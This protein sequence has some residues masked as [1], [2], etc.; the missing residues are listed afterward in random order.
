MS[1][2]NVSANYPQN[3]SQEKYLL[4]EVATGD[5]SIYGLGAYTSLPKLALE[6]AIRI[7]KSS[8]SFSNIR[9]APA[10]KHHDPMCIHVEGRK[11]RFAPPS[12]TVPSTR[13]LTPVE[14]KRLSHELTKALHGL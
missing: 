13:P 12:R 2:Y 9:T 3:K 10:Q 5:P 1:K 8:D 6:I 11:V 14:M 4:E 7:K